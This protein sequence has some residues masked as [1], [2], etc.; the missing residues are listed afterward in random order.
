MKPKRKDESPKHDISTIT[1]AIE[2]IGKNS[3]SK[4]K[5]AK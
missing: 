2:S 1:S 5:N 4:D 3:R